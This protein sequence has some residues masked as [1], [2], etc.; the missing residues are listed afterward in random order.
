MPV[1][2]F[3][4]LVLVAALASCQMG[5]LSPYGNGP[6]SMGGTTGATPAMSIHYISFMPQMDTV[7]VNT[8]VTWT[9]MDGVD[10]N[11]TSNT[12]DAVVFDSPGSIA[13][14]GGTYSFTFTT[15]GTFPYTCTIHGMKGTIV[16][17]P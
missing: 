14:N 16:V 12:G 15:A 9:N 4:P 11:V 17:T 5:S 7:P 6:G 3:L 1:R 10:H 2:R 13:P 8:T